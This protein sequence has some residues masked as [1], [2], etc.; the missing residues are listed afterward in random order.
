MMDITVFSNGIIIFKPTTSTRTEST[1]SLQVRTV[2]LQ[3]SPELPTSFALWKTHRFLIRTFWVENIE[4]R[5]M[6]K[7]IDF[8]NLE[9]RS[10]EVP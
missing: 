9:F 2:I 5:S 10:M 6:G 8:G 7:P 3:I 1:G 4:F